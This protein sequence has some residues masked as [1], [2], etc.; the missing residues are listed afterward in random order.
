MYARRLIEDPERVRAIARQNLQS[1]RGLSPHI[2][3]WARA[4]EGLLGLPTHVLADLVVDDGEFARSTPSGR[5]AAVTLARIDTN[6]MSEADRA[7]WHRNRQRALSDRGGHGPT[8]G[9]VV[10]ELA[11]RLGCYVS[12]PDDGDAARGGRT[13][14]ARRPPRLG[15][16]L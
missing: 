4:W 12:T 1:M 9:R 7:K 8:L 14:R 16:D 11:V 10:D 13:T 2:H 3:P 15:L 6:P 5:R